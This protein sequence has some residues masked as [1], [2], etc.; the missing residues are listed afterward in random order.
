MRH[1]DQDVRTFRSGRPAR[2]F[3]I[4]ATTVSVVYAFDLTGAASAYLAPLVTLASVVAI[5]VGA[6][7]NRPAPLFAWWLLL[8]ISILFAAGIS[9]RETTGQNVDLERSTILPDLLTVPGY[10]LF[11]VMLLVLIRSRQ[12]G[13]SEGVG[14]DAT[15]FALASFVV[16]YI[17]LIDPVL[18]N[19]EYGAVAQ[20]T[21]SIYPPLSAFLVLLA[22]R[23]AFTPGPRSITLT[24]FLLGMVSLFVGDVAQFLAETHTAVPPLNLLDLPY[25]LAYSFIAAALLHP[26]IRRVAVERADHSPSLRHVRAAV[27]STSLLLPCVLLLLW[28]PGSATE[29]LAVGALTVVLTALGTMRLIVATQAQARSEAR[30]AHRATHDALTSLPNRELLLEMID[31][32]LDEPE[33]AQG[34]GVILVDLDRF[35]LVNDTLGHVAGDRLLLECAQRVVSEVRADGIVGRISGDE[36][37]VLLRGASLDAALAVAERLR[38]SFTQPIDIGQPIYLTVSIGLSHTMVRIA[39]PADLLREADTAVY[40]SKDKG[41]NRVTVFEREMLE[42]DERRVELEHALRLALG[43]G[44]LEVYYQPIVSIETGRVEGFEALSR[45]QTANGWIPPSEFVSIAEDSGLISQLGSWILRESCR[46]LSRWRTQPEFHHATVS[47]NLSAR[48]LG[49]GLVAL[50]DETLRATGLPGEALWLEITESMMLDDTTELHDILGDIRALGVRFSL[51]DFGTGF[52]SLS[53]L[54]RYPLDRL[55]IDRSFVTGLSPASV[56]GSLADAIVSIGRSLRL[57]TVAEGVETVDET[58]ALWS[59]GCPLAQGYYF[60]RPMPATEVPFS[61]GRIAQAWSELGLHS[62]VLTTVTPG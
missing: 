22:A 24:Y 52:S 26:S 56:A 41:R 49:P 59:L 11:A 12:A 17:G 28:H 4:V 37:V 60:A 53:Y 35:K 21:F 36:F 1:R 18:A 51:D 13:R 7:R 38:A 23:L 47:V 62:V 8:P 9:V 30:F 39:D 45:W 3:L 32:A 34:L 43:A 31:A 33:L 54:R 40:R 44:E 2:T 55:K 48:Q 16:F 27:V 46:Q 50:V 61:L 29:Q 20:V 14:L 57:S 6:W 15:M 25:A 58:L 10:L 42:V 5:S 19:G